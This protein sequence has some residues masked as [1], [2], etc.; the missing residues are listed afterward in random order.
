MDKGR[1][2]AGIE[3]V[4]LRAL[5]A[6]VS[7]GK[8]KKIAIAAAYWLLSCTWGLL[9]TVV[10]AF[11]ALGALCLGGKPERNGPSAIIRIG[12]GW[13]GVS[14]G[15]FALCSKDAG[16]AVRKHEFGHSLQNCLM[17]PIWP[18]IVGIPSAIRYWA[19]ERNRRLGKEN[20]DYY[21]AWFEATASDW[22]TRFMGHWEGE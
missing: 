15:A 16:E 1:K 13:G 8:A 20:F 17:G 7:M 18:F 10:G 11:M 3:S 14:I 12:R 2:E 21:S 22:G 5:S 6:K 4:R 9:S 19:Y